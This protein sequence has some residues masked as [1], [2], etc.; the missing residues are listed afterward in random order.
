MWSFKTKS[1]NTKD[2]R[3]FIKVLSTLKLQL[4]YKSIALPVFVVE[5]GDI[6][7]LDTSLKYEIIFL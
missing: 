4:L 1:N 2:Y 7:S 5:E 3:Y 6:N